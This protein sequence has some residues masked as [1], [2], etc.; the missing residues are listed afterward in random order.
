MNTLLVSVFLIELIVTKLYLKI[1]TET[2]R[3]AE[4]NCTLP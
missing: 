3:G 1:E 4:I 2:N